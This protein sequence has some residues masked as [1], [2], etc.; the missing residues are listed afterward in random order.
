M[1]NFVS[2]VSFSSFLLEFH[3]QYFSSR[4]LSILDK[5]SEETVAL[6]MGNVAS[7]TREKK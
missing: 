4:L 7:E 3:L 5:S 1:C 2:S 6:S